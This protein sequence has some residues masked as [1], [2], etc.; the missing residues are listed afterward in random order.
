MEKINMNTLYLENFTYEEVEN[1]IHNFKSH[2]FTEMTVGEIDYQVKCLFAKN[3]M[4]NRM[5]IQP[6][7]PE[8]SL[9]Y[10]IRKIKSLKDLANEQGF[11]NNPNPKLGRL[12]ASGEEVLYACFERDAV[13]T[14]MSEAEIG[15]ED[16][17]AIICY[18]SIDQIICSQ[19]GAI[20]NASVEMKK[21]LLVENFLE[22]IF[23]KA[24]SSVE[25]GKRQLN[26]T[27]TKNPPFQS[28]NGGF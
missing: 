14:A 28:W 7:L 16:I 24:V 20:D 23:T 6:L 27:L 15:D 21:H 4:I 3:G 1:R 5:T 10:R 19:I 2:D 9:F 22:D 17:F 18:E 12:N 11:W 26:R 8:G 25:Q 13:V